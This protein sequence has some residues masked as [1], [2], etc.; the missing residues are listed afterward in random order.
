MGSKKT[1]KVLA[2]EFKEADSGFTVSNFT[3][4]R[5]RVRELASH[6]IL[7]NEYPFSLIEYVIFN[8]FMSAITPYW[9]K[10]SR[11][12]AKNECMKTYETEKIKLKALLKLVN[13]AHITTDM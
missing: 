12:A 7:Y 2:V 11:A 13:K 9:E 5:S 10:M 3:Y 6:M 4:D 8:K 1:Q